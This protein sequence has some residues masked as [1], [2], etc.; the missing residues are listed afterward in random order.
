MK[1]IIVETAA[2]YISIIVCHVCAYFR[3]QNVLSGRICNEKPT[4]ETIARNRASSFCTVCQRWKWVS[5]SLVM[6]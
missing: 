2:V 6:G 5:G 3:P 4:P 1:C